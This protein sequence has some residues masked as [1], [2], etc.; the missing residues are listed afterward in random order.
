MSSVTHF[1][2]Y[3]TLLTFYLYIIQSSRFP[4]HVGF[5]GLSLASPDVA[6]C[7]VVME[8][9]GFYRDEAVF[10]GQTRTSF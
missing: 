2:Q 5:P 1:N 9:F 3:F 4:Q 10:V 6:V 7:P 8:T